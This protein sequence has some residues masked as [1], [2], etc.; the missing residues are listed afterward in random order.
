MT[1]ALLLDDGMLELFRAEAESHSAALEAG[2]LGLE[3]GASRERLE[4]L[5]RAAHSIKGAAR[6]IGL[7]GAVGLAHAMEDA[8]VAAQKGTLLIGPEVTD[9]LLAGV[10]VFKRLGGLAPETL[11][12]WLAEHS[13]EMASLAAEFTLARSPTLPPATG[14][15]PAPPPVAPPDRPA[16]AAVAVSAEALDRLMGLSGE[17]LVQARRWPEFSRAL[18]EVKS[19]LTRLARAVEDEAGSGTALA[20]ALGPFGERVEETR[21][22]LAR[23]TDLVEGQ[24]QRNEEISARLYSEV[25][26]ARMR[27][28]SDGTKGFPRLVRDLARELGKEIT[29]ELTGEVTRVDRDVL[30]RLE[31]P[32]GHLLRNACDHGIESPE[33]RR[34]LGK[35]PGGW[36]R[37]SAEHR[38]GMLTVTVADDGRGIDLERIRSRVVERG[39]AAGGMAAQMT[40]AELGDFLFL[41]G[42]TTAGS[43]S[44][45]SGRGVGLDV[46]RSMAQEI[47]GSVHLASRPAEGTT[48]EMSLPL[49]LS[50]V[51]ALV[52]RVAGEPWALPLS[53]VDRVLKVP[54]ESLRAI[55][56]RLHADVDGEAIGLVPAHQPLGFSPAPASP[57]TLSVVVVSDRL[58]RFGLVVEA[59]LGERELVL[60][61][62]DPRLGDV[63]D[64]GSASILEDGTPVLVLDVDDLVR[65]ID[66]LLAGE[67]L[68]TVRRT[69]EAGERR[70]TRRVLVVDDSITVREVERRL[71]QNRGYEVDVAVDG[72]DGFNRV[73]S[74]RYDLVV[75]DVDMPRMS[76]IEMVSR[77]RQEPALSR[78]PVVIVSYKDREEDRLRGLEAG[79]SFYLTKGSFHDEQLINAV[80]DL[81]GEP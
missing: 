9:R 2:L 54:E 52:V 72:T 41:P 33:E 21:A 48:F 3:A 25:V 35:R 4:P 19:G 51:R 36:I 77:I 73:R 64:V 55:E 13:A 32:L 44:S 17:T 74:G 60:R 46:V 76:G 28:F 53:R 58:N 15:A 11:P 79:A 42:F 56:G 43:V 24:A 6:I 65:S 67:G 71:L 23:A 7:D 22:S 68:T 63:P 14:A 20:S 39:L 50:V 34:M 66:H 78:L 80:V 70:R 8:F 62:L 37:L 81:I 45:V 18:S 16:E 49:T 5:M 31:A 40:P 47:G 61:P 26:A 27:P 75:S 30:A 38:A 1:T 59:L 69:P 10:D 12:A 57:G 29:L